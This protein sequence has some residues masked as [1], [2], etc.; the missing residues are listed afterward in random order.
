MR[1]MWTIYEM[2]FTVKRIKQ[3]VSIYGNYSV[4]SISLNQ[5][6]NTGVGISLTFDQIEQNSYGKVILIAAPV[7]SVAGAEW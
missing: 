5:Y 2:R 4:P 7:T 6:H 3:W 1:A